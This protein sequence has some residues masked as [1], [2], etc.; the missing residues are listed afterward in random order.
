MFSLMS[1]GR[2]R[3][4]C[5][6]DSI[7]YGYQLMDRRKTYPRVLQRLLGEGCEVRNFGNPGCGILHRASKL[8]GHRAFIFMPQHEQ[9]LE[10]NP[11]IVLCN[12]GINDLMDW[13]HL[14]HEFIPDY[15]ALLADYRALASAP[16]VVI[17]HRLAPLFP[18]RPFH[19]DE[20]VKVLNEGIAEVARL[21][22]VETIEMEDPLAGHPEWF[23]DKLHPNETG[24]AEIAQ[25]TAEYLRRGE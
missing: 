14:G 15:R 20:R 9:A 1:E 5:V 11:D 12:L 23:P 25:V 2:R 13:D 19:G 3:V 8:N 4:A 17:W 16:R 10:W 18:G 22:E 24:A 7:T 21:E 6:G